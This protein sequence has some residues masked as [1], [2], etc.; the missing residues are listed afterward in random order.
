MISFIFFISLKLI[1]YHSNPQISRQCVSRRKLRH[2]SYKLAET[3]SK[4]DLTE[5]KGG[6]LYRR[7]GREKET[8][9]SCEKNSIAS[10]VS[11]AA[12]FVT[13]EVDVLDSRVVES[14]VM[15]PPPA[16]GVVANEK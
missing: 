15:C 6:G 9:L 16:L 14:F 7:T 12:A 3:K 10:C 8:F 1:A 2:D 13:Y 11:A 5:L 4:I